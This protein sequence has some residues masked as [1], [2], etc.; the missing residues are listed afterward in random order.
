M[1]RFADGE[2]MHRLC[3]RISGIRHRA[4]FPATVEKGEVAA[5][6]VLY[7][8]FSRKNGVI[9]R[10]MGIRI[11]IADERD[12][13]RGLLQG[14]VFEGRF[15]LKSWARAWIGSSA[16]VYLAATRSPAHLWNDLIREIA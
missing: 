5:G 8:I 14:Q 16:G 4:L 1:A 2:S 13:A 9:I 3:S 12:R 15:S 7:L 10:P 11:A 6:L